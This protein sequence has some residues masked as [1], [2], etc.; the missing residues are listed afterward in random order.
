MAFILAKLLLALLFGGSTLLLAAC[1]NLTLQIHATP[2]INPDIHG[3]P[4][5]TQVNFYL[6]RSD[7][8]FQTASFMALRNHA[9]TTLNKALLKQQSLSIAPGHTRTLVLP[10]NTTAH[11]LGIV[12]AYRVLPN[13]QWKQLIALKNLHNAWNPTVIQLQ[14]TPQGIQVPGQHL[15]HSL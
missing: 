4:S 5:P 7:G 11:F 12:A 15:G 13:S 14:L 3:I 9:Q 10:S 8:S 1:S 6:L 2:K